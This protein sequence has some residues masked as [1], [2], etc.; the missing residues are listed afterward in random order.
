MHGLYFQGSDAPHGAAEHFT[1]FTGSR[2]HQSLA[3]LWSSQ[4]DNH[5]DGGISERLEKIADEGFLPLDMPCR[6]SS[7]Y[8]RR[9]QYHVGARESADLA[10]WEVASG[11]ARKVGHL[12]GR[13]FPWQGYHWHLWRKCEI[14]SLIESLLIGPDRGNW[15][16]TEDSRAG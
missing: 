3:S 14:V 8:A 16:K 2:A 7:R 10:V 11:I 5:V 1:S 15:K 13:M 12:W 9:Q 4:A 6:H